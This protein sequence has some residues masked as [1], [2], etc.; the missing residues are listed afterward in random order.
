MAYR[1]PSSCDTGLVKLLGSNDFHS[2]D[3]DFALDGVDDERIAVGET[4]FGVLEYREDEKELTRTRI[5]K[6][7][8]SNRTRKGSGNL[9]RSCNT[10][11]IAMCCGKYL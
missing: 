10:N 3:N 4:E 9:E 1:Y 5:Q 8:I 7:A 2:K 11:G 6:Q